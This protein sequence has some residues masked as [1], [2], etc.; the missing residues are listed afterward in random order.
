MQS[1]SL[2]WKWQYTCTSS[3]SISRRS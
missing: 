3:V 2:F 1:L